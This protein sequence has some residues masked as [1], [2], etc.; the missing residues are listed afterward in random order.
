MENPLVSVVV[1]TYNGQ[2]YVNR[3]VQSVLKQTYK[4]IEVIIIN[5]GSTD[6]TK[7]IIQQLKEKN[8]RVSVLENEKNLGFVESLNRGVDYASGKYIARIDDDDVW[9]DEKKL[10]KQVDFLEKNSEYVLVGGG[11]I[12]IN[13]KEEEIIKYLPPEQ[14]TD[15]RNIIL[16][17]N[18]FGHSAVIF[19]K[20]VFEKVGG[21]DEKFGFFA[22]WD[23]W[24]KMGKVG[25]IHNLQEFVISYLDKEAYNRLYRSRDLQIRRQLGLRIA[26]KRKYKIDY[27]HFYK[28]VF[29]SFLSY[30]Y[31]FLPY[32]N[33]LRPFVSWLKGY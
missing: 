1:P 14:D 15:I 6:K 2:F 16:L 5:D 13:N 17:T 26:L 23:L 10:K 30:L 7:E 9:I 12:T 21:Y 19:L 24:L 8:S 3:A 4:N 18:C 28:A 20:S 11:L 31:S 29:L 22:D 25:K 27:P 33:K 32:K